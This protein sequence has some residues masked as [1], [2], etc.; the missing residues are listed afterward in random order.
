MNGVLDELAKQFE[1]TLWS[2][3]NTEKGKAYQ[4]MDPIH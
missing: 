2:T 4:Y 3:T 1:F